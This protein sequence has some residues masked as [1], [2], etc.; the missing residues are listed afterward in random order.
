V[1]LAQGAYYLATGTLPSVSRRLFEAAG[2]LA[3]LAASRR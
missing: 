2:V 3:A 1:L